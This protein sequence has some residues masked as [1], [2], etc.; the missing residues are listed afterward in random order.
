MLLAD[1][2]EGFEDEVEFVVGVRGHVGGAHEPLLTT[3]ISEAYS[4]RV[5]NR[6][7]CLDR[8]R[9]YLRVR[10]IYDKRE[11]PLPIQIAA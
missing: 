11:M 8:Y 4:I 1:A 7:S 9:R 6:R 5:V 10:L 3:R 2:F